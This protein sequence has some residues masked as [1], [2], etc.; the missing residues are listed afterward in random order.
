M[1]GVMDFNTLYNMGCIALLD[2]RLQSHKTANTDESNFPYRHE[3]CSC[4]PLCGY[5]CSHMA[6][7][8]GEGIHDGMMEKTD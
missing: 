6:S 4:P 2:C 1:K 7:Q 8:V 5:G 3:T